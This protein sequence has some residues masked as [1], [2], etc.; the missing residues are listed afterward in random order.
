MHPLE[1]TM[2]DDVHCCENEGERPR[3]KRL[4]LCGFIHEPKDE[5]FEM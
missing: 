5:N 1:Q 2:A 4:I 3:K